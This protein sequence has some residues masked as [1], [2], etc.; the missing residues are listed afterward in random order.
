MIL[1]QIW[2]ITYG[3][4]LMKNTKDPRIYRTKTIWWTKSNT[5]QG[6][7]EHS[8]KIQTLKFCW[9]WT[10]YKSQGYYIKCKVIYDLFR[11]EKYRGLTY[12]TLFRATIFCDFVLLNG[13]NMNS[14]TNIV[15]KKEIRGI[16]RSKV[17]MTLKIPPLKN[18]QF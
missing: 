12:T 17:Y 16:M 4:T 3:L 1:R 9:T 18:L 7:K 2:P 10:V 5:T 14:L 8:W 11:W 6:H 13:I 15:F